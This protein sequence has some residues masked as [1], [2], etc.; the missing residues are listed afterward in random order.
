LALDNTMTKTIVTLT[1]YI[2]LILLDMYRFVMW[3]VI[4][5]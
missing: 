3:P 1:K 4:G 2:T 5:K